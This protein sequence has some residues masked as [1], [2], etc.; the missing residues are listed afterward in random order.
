MSEFLNILNTV[1]VLG[2]LIACICFWLLKQKISFELELVKWFCLVQLVCNGT[3]FLFDV[4]QLKNY[5]I[6][7]LNMLVSFAILLWLFSKYLIDI[8]KNK[9]KLIGAF[10]YLCIGTTYYFY[11]WDN[12]F[13]S[14]GMALTS[15]ITVGFCLYFFYSRLINSSEELSIPDTSIFWCVVGI[16]T[17]FAGSFFIFISYKYLIDSDSST[18]S[19]LWRFH[20]ILLLICCLYISYGIICKNYR[21]ILS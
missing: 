13:N 2:P 8:S 10:V 12:S 15:V 7:E 20:N 18:V 21:T 5:W 9:A 16:F 3:A 11:G 6:Y 19:T 17:Y 14:Y 4:L 1:D